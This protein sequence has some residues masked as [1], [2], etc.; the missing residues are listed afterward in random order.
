[1]QSRIRSHA[2]QEIARERSERSGIARE[3][4]REVSVWYAE[5]DSLACGAR[6]CLQEVREVRY[7]SRERKRSAYGMQ[8]RIR[9]HVE[10]EIAREGSERSGIA[11]ERSAYGMQSKEMLARGREG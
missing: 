1:M 4:S 11:R 5:Q 2:E 7:C 10:Q 3:R 6:N 9:S 8:S